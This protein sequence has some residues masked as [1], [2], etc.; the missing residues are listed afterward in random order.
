MAYPHYRSQFGDTTFTKV[1]VGGLAW[2][3]PTEEMRKY[4]EQFGE[5][6]EAVIITDKNTGKSKGYGFVTFRDPESARRACAD[7]NPVIDGRRANCNIA[8]LGRPRPSPPRGR[9][10]FQGG[11]PGTASYSGVPAAG[12]SALAPPPPPPPPPLVYPPYGYPTYTPDYGYHQATLY[13][14]QIQQPQYYQQLYGPSSST[15]ASPYYY[16]YSVQAPRGTFSTPQPHRIPAG[17]SYL[18]YPTPMEGSFS[19][20]RPPPQLQQLPIRQPP[21]SP[22]DSQTQQRTSSE[23]AGGVVITSES[24]NTQGRN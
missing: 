15:M 17:P 12:P 13:N 14:P 10:T 21:P 6:L 7:P 24:S 19:A 9:G 1:F 4:F 22:S 23:A 5:I 18:Y 20:Y 16:G 2:E 8:S 3:T 11:A